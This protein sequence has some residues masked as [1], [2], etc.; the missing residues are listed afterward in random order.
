[1]DAARETYL[2]FNKDM[3]SQMPRIEINRISALL[4]SERGNDN[5]ASKIMEETYVKAG[6]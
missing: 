1:M 3:V 2:K 4:E 6:E 5:E